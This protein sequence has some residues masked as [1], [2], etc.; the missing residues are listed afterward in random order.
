MYFTHKKYGKYQNIG[1]KL[2][3]NAK[4]LPYMIRALKTSCNV[5]TKAGM[6]SDCNLSP[7]LNQ[8]R[9]SLK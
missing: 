7:I 3:I 4:L 2:V 9:Y 6:S 5:P 8:G 1:Y